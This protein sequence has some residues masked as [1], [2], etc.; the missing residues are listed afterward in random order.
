MPRLTQLRAQLSTEL[1]RA[2]TGADAE[3]H[4]L[5]AY[6]HTKLMSNLA[7]RARLAAAQEVAKCM[8]EMPEAQLHAILD[9]YRQARPAHLVCTCPPQHASHQLSTLKLGAQVLHQ[10]Q[11]HSEVWLTHVAWYHAACTGTGLAAGEVPI[12]CLAG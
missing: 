5:I 11:A 12:R 1:K 2:L 4:C 10:L 9:L 8:P 6:L 3:V 7:W